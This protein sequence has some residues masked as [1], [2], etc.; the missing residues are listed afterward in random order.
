M[1]K[2]NSM[3]ELMGSVVKDGNP[4]EGQREVPESHTNKWVMPFMCLLGWTIGKESQ[5]GSI[6]S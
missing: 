1:D 6:E 3:W 4:K 5:D 2:V